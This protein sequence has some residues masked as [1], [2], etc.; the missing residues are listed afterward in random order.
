MM[1][2][3]THIE[4]LRDMDAIS[5]TDFETDC[6]HVLPSH[7]KRNQLTLLIIGDNGQKL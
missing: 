7:D 4:Y 5:N 1:I 2:R 6:T 3:F